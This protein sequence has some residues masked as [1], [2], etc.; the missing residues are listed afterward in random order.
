VNGEDRWAKLEEIVRRVVKEELSTWNPQKKKKVEFKNGKWLGLGT[1]EMEALKAAYPAVSV[2]AELR[3]M[4]AWLLMNPNDAPTSNYG[5]FINTWLRRNQNQHSLRSIPVERPLE[6]RKL[7][8][9][10]DQ[11]STGSTSGT[12]HCRAH[13]HDAMD[14]KPP[15]R[16]LN[17]VAK[18]VA[19]AD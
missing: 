17:V 1:I 6:A 10:C 14:G 11:P 3:N 5:A 16:M 19:G 7:C 15:R 2:D 8:A 12:Y 9:Y 4:S 18:P 13:T